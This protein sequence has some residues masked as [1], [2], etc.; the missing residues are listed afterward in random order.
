M[1]NSLIGFEAFGLK[2][3]TVKLERNSV[4]NW[5]NVSSVRTT[6]ESK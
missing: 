2:L 3:K 1:N 4:I 5:R 6:F